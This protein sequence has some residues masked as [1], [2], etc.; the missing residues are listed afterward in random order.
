MAKNKRI[1]NKQKA[2]LLKRMLPVLIYCTFS[3]IM[4][5]I[6]ALMANPTLRDISIKEGQCKLTTQGGCKVK[7]VVEPIEQT[8]YMWQ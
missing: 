3:A 7:V 4:G 1:H 2:V 6:V 8:I 5:G